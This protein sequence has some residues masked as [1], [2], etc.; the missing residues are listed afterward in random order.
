MHISTMHSLCSRMPYYIYYLNYRALHRAYH[1]LLMFR[2][3]GLLDVK[4]EPQYHRLTEESGDVG[5]HAEDF[6]NKN[7]RT[8]ACER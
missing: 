5:K 1:V 6:G 3:Y 8:I 2:D 4:P 7:I